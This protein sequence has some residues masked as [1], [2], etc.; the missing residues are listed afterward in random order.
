[1]KLLGQAV[2]NFLDLCDTPEKCGEYLTK[3][4]VQV[5]ELEGTF[6]E[7][8]EYIEELA[9]KREE[10]YEAFEGRKQALVEQR[11]PRA[12]NLLKSA[13]RILA[14]TPQPRRLAGRH[15]RD[16]RLFRR[17]SDGFERSATSSA[18]SRSIGDT[19]KA[20]DLQTRLKTLQED[21][22]RQLKDRKELF[23][24]G[25]NVS[26]V[27][28]AQFL[29]QH[30]GAGTLHRPPRGHD[31]LS[32][33]PAPRFSSRSRDEEFLATR[34]VWEQQVISENTRVYRA[35]WLAWQMLE[36][37]VL[38]KATPTHR[39]TFRRSWRRAM[40]KATPRAST[41]RTPADSRRDSC[42]VHRG[43]WPA[44]LRPA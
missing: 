14:G 2:V 32:I 43:A 27:R 33:S 7:F 35:E 19:V 12:G 24:D 29:G 3:V 16:Q 34:D 38:R 17:R 15:Q 41:T 28:Q 4:M 25:G 10:I 39:R 20:D 5:E 18:S 22:V 11:Q 21:A 42:P 37:D 44:A 6:A 8:D 36:Q 31:V 13:E 30:P 40:R 1:M 23:V 9:R 26:E